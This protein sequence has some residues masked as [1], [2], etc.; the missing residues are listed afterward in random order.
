[1]NAKSENLNLKSATDALE[2]LVLAYYKER[3]KPKPGDSS[4]QFQSA[5][6][7][8]LMSREEAYREHIVRSPLTGALRLAIR[9]IGLHIWSKT[10]S[11][12]KMQEALYGAVNRHPGKEQE[13]IDATD[14]AW[15]GIGDCWWA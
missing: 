1:M 7:I 9:E 11:T 14:K 6:D 12:D 8:P 5:A 2:V 13:L 10:G 15:D 3:H 4:P